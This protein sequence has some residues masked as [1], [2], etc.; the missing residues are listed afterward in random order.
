ML[1]VL[2]YG[3]ASRANLEPLAT[4]REPVPRL[5]QGA[6]ARILRIGAAWD[7]GTGAKQHAVPVKPDYSALSV[8]LGS[9]VVT[10]LFWT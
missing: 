5:R 9:T 2:V 7:S 4:D 3:C 1:A 8:P 6:R 10:A